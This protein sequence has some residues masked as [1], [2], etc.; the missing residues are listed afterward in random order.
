MT[1]TTNYNL[2]KFEATDRVTR[3][4]F[5][6]NA[7]AIDAAL[8]SVS[9]A[10]GTAQSTA[11]GALA[12]A[13]AAAAAGC[14]VVVGTYTGD[15]TKERTIDLG[16]QPKAVYVC[17]RDGVIFETKSGDR[18][19][20]GGLAVQGDGPGPTYGTSS[21][22]TSYTAFAITSTG[23]AVYWENISSWYAYMATNKS[24]IFYH[25]VA[26]L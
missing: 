5:N 17:P 8:K 16:G 23:F 21:N 4:G 14:R 3:D 10:A 11:S 7:D 1:H 2:N 26:L 19:F 15:G 9:D 24:D 6:D 20:Y 25:Y 18:Y 22:R 12:A 13:Q